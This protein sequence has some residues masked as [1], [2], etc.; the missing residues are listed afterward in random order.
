MTTDV[1]LLDPPSWMPDWLVAPLIGGFSLADFLDLFVLLNFILV[2]VMFEIWLER[3][4]GGHIQLR[5]GPRHVGPHGAL[6]SPA[7]V[8]KLLTK[9]DLLPAA[10]LQRPRGTGRAFGL[11]ATQRRQRLPWRTQYGRPS[12]CSMGGTRSLSLAGA[13]D[14][15]RSA[16]KNRTSMWS[17]AGMTLSSVPADREADAV[18]GNV[19]VRRASASPPG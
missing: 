3:K 12:T 2:F 8:L 16:G 9:E 10:A 19:G 6:Q 18:H 1:V 14:V 13:R 15:H 4:V 11:V 17:S 7:D 5:R